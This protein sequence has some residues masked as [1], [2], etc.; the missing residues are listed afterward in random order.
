MRKVFISYYHDDDQ[1]YKNRLIQLNASF[2][3]FA[4]NSV[5][6]G[7][8][9]DEFLTDEQIRIKIRDD[10]IKDTDVFILLCGKNTKHRKHIDWEIHAAMYKSAVKNPIPI[11]VIN[12]P[13]CRNG[14]RKNN[15]QEKTII[16]KQ[17]VLVWKSFST[18]IEYI[19]CYPDLPKR[20]LDS[21]I[22]KNT[23]VT[24]VNWDNLTTDD[25]KLLIELSYQRR[26]EY[27]YDDSSLLR[28]RNGENEK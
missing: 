21:L 20:L 7:D 22:N 3:M 16:E 13:G 10:Y 6:I 1:C 8:I 17:T 24:I 19:N 2:S 26:W 9:D 5:D 28:R 12:L 15:N 11:L 27:D 18:A 23:C 4:D 14:C 25:L